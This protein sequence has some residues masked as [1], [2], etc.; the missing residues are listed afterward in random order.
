MGSL[1]NI[2]KIYDGIGKI[3]LQTFK[4]VY[5]QF[6][7]SQVKLPEVK[8]VDWN[9][10]IFGDIKRQIEEQNNLASQQIDIL[11]QQNGLLSDNYDKLKEMYDEQAIAYRDSNEELHRSRKYN[12]W[13][14]V[15][16]IVA[17]L[18]A[19]AGPIVTV[20]VSK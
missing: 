8:P 13:M 18:A 7:Y 11:I 12:R 20:I 1:D 10:T 17:M 2:S 4:P 5:P 19:I 3:N 16:A 14:M 6:D 15:I 9:E